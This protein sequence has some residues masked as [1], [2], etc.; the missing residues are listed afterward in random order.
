MPGRGSA[1]FML[2]RTQLAVAL[3]LGARGQ[4]PYARAPFGPS[5]RHQCEEAEPWFRREW[6]SAKSAD[7]MF[8][9]KRDLLAL[10]VHWYPVSDPPSRFSSSFGRECAHPFLR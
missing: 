6:L 10:R 7:V 9:R 4:V 8:P 2:A 3:R 1:A 5:R